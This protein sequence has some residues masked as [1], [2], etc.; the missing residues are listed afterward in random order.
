MRVRPSK[1]CESIDAP[2]SRS[3]LTFVTFSLLVA[4]KSSDSGSPYTVEALEG[5]RERGPRSLEL[6]LGGF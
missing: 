5:C 3:S 6:M 1:S 2:A 4:R